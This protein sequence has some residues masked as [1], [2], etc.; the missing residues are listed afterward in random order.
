MRRLG[1]WLVFLGAGACPR[2]RPRPRLARP[3]L[4][5]ARA[6]SPDVRCGQSGLRSLDVCCASPSMASLANNAGDRARATPR[7]FHDE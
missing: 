7:G 4:G 3:R 1:D 5:V 2:P 6:P